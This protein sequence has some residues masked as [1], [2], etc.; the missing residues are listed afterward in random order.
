MNKILSFGL[1][2]FSILLFAFLIHSS[3]QHYLGFPFSSFLIIESYSINFLLVLFSFSI[4]WLFRNK[5]A[6]SLGF[7]FLAGFF[8]KLLV[9][10]IFFKPEYESDGTIDRAEFLAF[11]VPYA[12]ALILETT[13]LV[14]YLNKA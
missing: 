4:L 7:L 3:L 1:L 13:Q 14:R 11:F 6:S 12:L 5:L 9:F 8:F 10:F 2:L